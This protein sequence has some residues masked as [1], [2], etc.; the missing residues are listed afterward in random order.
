MLLGIDLGTTALK[1]AAYDE[2]SGKLLHGVEERLTVET[3]SNGQR[4]QSPEAL[5]DTLRKA[6]Q[7][8]GQALGGLA[9][10][11]GIGLAAQGGSTCIVDAD[12]GAPRT[13]L[14]LWNDG[15]AFGH[16]LE[17]AKAHPVRFWRTRTQRDEPGMGLARIVWLREE[18]PRLFD[19]R[20]L[21]AGAGELAFHVLT[22]VWRQ[23]A[24]N[25]M[26]S[27]VYDTR[28]QALSKEMAALADVTPEFF[29]PLRN[30]HETHPVSV[31]AV[32]A[33]GLP[34][35][36]PVAGPYMDHEAGFLSVV[37]KSERPLQC[38]LGTA[39]VGNFC[40]PEGVTGQSPF[41]FAIPAPHREGQLVIQPLLTGNVTWDWA[42]ST[43]VDVDPEQALEKQT[44]IF[45]QQIAPEPGLTCLPWLNRPN[46]LAPGH[47]GDATFHGLSPAT[48]RA[49]LVRA[50]ATGMC[51]ELARVFEQVVN[52]G[53]VDSV[54][55]SGGASKG[56][57]FRRLIAAV[58]PD[59]PV[60]RVTEEAWMGTRGA[61]YAFSKKVARARTG[62]ALPRK[63]S[64]LR[65]GQH[66]EL[67]MELWNRLCLHVTA[68]Q[69]YT[70]K[71]GGQ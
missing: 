35:G 62:R 2:K 18:S 51:F 8:V 7:Q 50:V 37:D 28:K 21:Y 58:F 59:L 33:F 19:G 38:S 15:R 69:A 11:R 24:C 52:A 63:E 64:D 9:Q 39:W 65:L 40:L 6:I 14:I 13:P 55:L 57:Q 30:G 3:G 10:I 66:Q 60:Y 61:L 4:E 41:Q 68:G 44:A 22:G 29:A 16:F 34:E 45:E 56:I 70:I 26:Q 36:I 49:E 48:D 46:S 5:A 23:D 25:A 31:N 47:L 12:S 67:Y 43:F 54:V 71:K 27:G 17:L 20:A 42:L 53:V 1:V 32:K